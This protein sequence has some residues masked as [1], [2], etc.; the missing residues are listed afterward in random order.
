M[1]VTF[2]KKK[3]VFFF[4]FFKKKLKNELNILIFLKKKSLTFRKGYKFY[5]PIKNITF[6]DK[7]GFKD[8]LFFRPNAGNPSSYLTQKIKSKPYNKNKKIPKV[9]KYFFDM[10]DQKQIIKK[11]KRK[12]ADIKKINF[13]SNFSYRKKE[14]SI[15]LK[16]FFLKK[17]VL[18][19]KV[20]SFFKKWSGK[21]N[22][23]S[24]FFLL[25]FISLVRSKLIKFVLDCKFFIKKGFI[26]ING[27]VVRDPL[28]NLKV[29]DRI[30]IPFFK[31]YY[32][33]TRLGKKFFKKKIKFMK[34]KFF[35]VLSSDKPIQ[36]FYS[37]NPIFLKKFIFFN[38]DIPSN[39]EVDFFILTAIVLKKEK[40]NLKKNI[41]LSKII[42]IFLS[43]SYNWKRV[44]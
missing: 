10:L 16:S 38:I 8:S 29:G 2:N 25:L 36:T 42:S 39:I 41:Y 20:D 44:S 40:H 34:R 32:H 37:W 24:N 35:K 9:S 5:K 22:Y 43:K 17:R 30:Q 28:F 3:I 6:Q 31:K 1:L 21:N 15:F 27:I 4:K 19:K 33:Y 7:L 11:Q 26:F 13:K 12:R 14:N 23:Y 18:K